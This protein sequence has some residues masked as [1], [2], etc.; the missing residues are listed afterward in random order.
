MKALHLTLSNEPFKIMEAGLKNREY[1]I[2]NPNW[3][4]SRL[5]DS[6]T[7]KL[8]RYDVVVFKNGYGKVPY[9]VCTYLGFEIAK[10][11]YSVTYKK[12]FKVDVKKGMY[13][14]KLGAIVRRGNIFSNELF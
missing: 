4:K 2:N 5:I 14:I 9:F 11:N 1:R 7:G 13:R 8:K 6:K 3:I 10:K 12:G